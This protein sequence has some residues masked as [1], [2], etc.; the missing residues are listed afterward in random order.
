MLVVSLVVNLARLSSTNAQIAHYNQKIET[1]Q[2][3]ESDNSQAIKYMQSDEYA[4]KYAR[5]YLGLTDPDDEVFI[6]E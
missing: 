5:E 2:K 4:E 3:I 6:A 1:L